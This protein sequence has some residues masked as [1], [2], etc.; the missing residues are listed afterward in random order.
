MSLTLGRI[1]AAGAFAGLFALGLVS[2]SAAGS[3]FSGF[4]NFEA[5]SVW[6]GPGVSLL[7]LGVLLGAGSTL[8]RV[9]FEDSLGNVLSGFPQASARMAGVVVL[10]LA[11]LQVV[12]F[13]LS[14]WTGSSLVQTSTM[15]RTLPAFVE[16]EAA[17]YPELGTLVIEPNQEGFDAS[18]ER[19][20][21]TSLSRTSTLLR[22]RSTELSAFEEDLARLVATLVRQSAAEPGPLME[23]YGIR[24]IWLKTPA[25]SEAAL[26]I[27]QRPELV[28]ASSAEAGQLW[29][30]PEV[31]PGFTTSAVSSDGP[32]Q[33]LFWVVF[34]LG[35]L[36][37]VPTERRSRPGSRRA[38]DALPSL[39]EETSDND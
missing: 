10:T 28:G 5:V 25:E 26:A 8:D 27:A 18:L 7:W 34:A 23:Q 29:Q 35:V 33:H 30:V 1:V 19:G 21:G 3:M 37:A 39:G 36:L 6:P 9:D 11:G 14:T 15:W 24:F 20:L 2:A 22:G 32:H 12:P 17:L 16:A 4:E 38:D 31:S 13:T